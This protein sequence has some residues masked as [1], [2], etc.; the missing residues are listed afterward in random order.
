MAPRT[1]R[2]R[3]PRKHRPLASRRR[4]EV[5]LEAVCENVAQIAMAVGAEERRAY[6]AMALHPDAERVSPGDL[7]REAIL[8]AGRGLTQLEAVDQSLWE[9]HDWRNTCDALA[10][11]ICS[12]VRRFDVEQFLR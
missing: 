11:A 2:R 5:D 12:G 3:S 6:D 8:G 10:E 1:P 9:R 4:T 7:V